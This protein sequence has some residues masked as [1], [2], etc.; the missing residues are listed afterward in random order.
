MRKRPHKCRKPPFEGQ[1]ERTTESRA[2]RASNVSR[3]KPPIFQ[4]SAPSARIPAKSR[5]NTPYKGQ[6][7]RAA[8]IRL[9][10]KALR[11]IAGRLVHLTRSAGNNANNS[12]ARRAKTRIRFYIPVPTVTV[13]AGI[14]MS[15]PSMEAVKVPLS[16][17]WAVFSITNILVGIWLKGDTVSVLPLVSGSST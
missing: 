12:L 14:S 15:Q 1:A 7:A 4:Q 17:I 2:M 11:H 8:R 9:M 16:P 5:V 6:R 10:K 3:V 13:Q